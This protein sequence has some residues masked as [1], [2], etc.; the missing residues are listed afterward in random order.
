MEALFILMGTGALAGILVRLTAYI[1]FRMAFYASRKKRTDNAHFSLPPGDIYEPY[2]GIMYNWAEEAKKLPHEDVSIISFDGLKLC[3]KLYTYAPEAPIEIMMHGYRGTAERDM[4]G[5]VQRA[6]SLGR[7]ALIIDQRACGKS[8]GTVISFGINERHDCLSWIH[9]VI[10]RFGPDVRII[11]AGISMGASTVMMAGGMALP[12]NVIGIIA[13]CGYTSPR[14]IIRKVIRD[15]KLPDAIAYPFVRL[16]A[17]LYG[18]FDLEEA[19]CVEAM[20]NCRVP[21]FFAHGENDDFVPCHMSIVNF[22]AC[23][24]PKKL[25]T[26]PGAGHG[27]CYPAAS[28]AYIQT[29]Q[30]IEAYY[31]PAVIT[32]TE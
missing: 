30:E 7:S 12:E 24:A 18:H 13:D 20:K 27:L 11:L 29:L 31:S 19:S 15:M 21:V 28:E 22:D 16:G 23:S 9:F 2:R 17:K 4:C 5:G 14:D 25:L 8:E 26:V 1:C 6:F 3:G 10:G 32:A